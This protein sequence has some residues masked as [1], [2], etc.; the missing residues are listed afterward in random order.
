MIFNFI[1]LINLILTLFVSI[2]GFL[3]LFYFIFVLVHF[4]LLSIYFCI[5][6]NFQKKKK[7]EE[8]E[9]KKNTKKRRKGEREKVEKQDIKDNNTP[10]MSA[11]G[12]KKYEKQHPKNIIAWG[13]KITGR[14][15][16]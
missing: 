5:H 13:Q 12:C 1:C 2:L 3:F 4:I 9:K 10:D 6:L 14:L 11:S 8:K 16:Q 15:K 7:K